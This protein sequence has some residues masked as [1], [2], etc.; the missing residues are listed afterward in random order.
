MTRV[1]KYIFFSAACLILPIST[2]LVR[3]VEPIPAITR[4]SKDVTLST[5]TAGRIAAINVKQGDSVK[6]GDIL[7]QLYD[8]VERAKLAQLQAQSEDTTQVEA[9]QAKW[10][11]KKV[12]LEKYEEAFQKGAATKLEFQYAKLEAKIAELSLRIA[13][14]EHDQDIRKYTELKLQVE[15]MQLKSPIDG[16]VEKITPQA[17]ESVNALQP[18]IQVVQTKPLWID[19]PAPMT[20]TENLNI[21]QP[22][23]IK[24]PGGNLEKAKII[25]IASVA[26]AAS[27]TVNIRI[28]S[29]NTLS[30]RAGE[31]ILVILTP[32][33]NEPNKSPK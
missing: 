10:D 22:V 28:E 30:R 7:V 21:N 13:K 17:G 19:V 27:S 11:Q 2:N 16:R 4:P 1:K 32:T 15:T 24:F 31:H 29:P 8:A 3:A 9:A 6:G 12:D 25:F 14:F 26:D 20:A 5:I 18:V 33:E 23:T